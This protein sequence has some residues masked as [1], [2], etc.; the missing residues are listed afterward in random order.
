MRV[1]VGWSGE[2]ADKVWQKTDVEL[3]EQD[4][5]RV[6][7]EADLPEDLAERLPAKVCFQLLQNEAEMMLLS[8]LRFFG[9]PPE[10]AT[11]RT[12][13]LLGS[14]TEILNAIRAQL[15]PA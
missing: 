8:K 10:K 3:E 15:A 12:A 13:V 6:I 7:R 4:L 5:Q 9:Y 1:R 14:T 11:A 2:T